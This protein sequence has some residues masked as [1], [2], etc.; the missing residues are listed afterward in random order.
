MLQSAFKRKWRFH[1]IRVLTEVLLLVAVVPA[2]A[3]APASAVLPSSAIDTILNGRVAVLP[4]WLPSAEVAS[5]RQ[6]A[7]NLQRDGHFSADAL[8]AYGAEKSTAFDASKDRTVLR[9]NKW[10]D[11]RLGNFGLRQRFGERMASLR[12]ALA[13]G[14]ER[15]GLARGTSV[16]SY[17]GGSTE[18]SYTRYGDGAYLKRHVDE[19]HEELKLRRGWANPT[20]RSISWLVY[21][22]EEDWDVERD[23]GELRCFERQCAHVKPP[24]GAVA[25]G[26]LQIGLLRATAGDPIERPV[27]LDSRRRSDGSVVSG[28]GGGAAAAANRG[29]CAMYVVGENDRPIYVTGNFFAEPVLFLVGDFF[30]KQL[31][32]G[33]RPDL[34]ARFHY[35]EP[36]KSAA[37]SAAASLRAPALSWSS[38]LPPSSKLINT[39]PSSGEVALNVAPKGGTL[40]VFDSVSLPHEVLPTSGRE[41]WATSGWFHEDQ[42]PEHQ[43]PQALGWESSSGV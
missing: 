21:L 14:L 1:D 35:L 38:S 24:I 13:E 6:D 37:A 40:V 18:I 15:P 23:G 34:A 41:R 19:H 8:A 31:L 43:Q 28:G 33:R 2:A 42:Q 20:R 26:D 29:N 22:N 36:P 10:K 11:A 7:M 5:L 17:G 32:N 39:T 16:S 27:F 30:G 3:L 4:N 12:S 25:N 9:L